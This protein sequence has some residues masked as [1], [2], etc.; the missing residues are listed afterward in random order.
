MLKRIFSNIALTAL[1]ALG[2]IGLP[3]VAQNEG[4]TANC[5]GGG[6]AMVDGVCRQVRMHS[7][8]NEM[9]VPK[10]IKIGAGS[11]AYYLDPTTQNSSW[12][13]CTSGIG[14]QDSTCVVPYRYGPPAAL[15]TITAGFTKDSPF[16]GG[17]GTSPRWTTTNAVSLTVNCSGVA[18]YNNAN[19]PLQAWPS[20]ILFKSLVTGPVTCVLT[21][22]NS[23][24]E[25]TTLT[26]TANFI[27]P[28]PPTLQVG[29]MRTSFNVGTG[30]SEIYWA[31]QNAVTVYASC[32]GFNWG[33]GYVAVQGNPS[34]VRMDLSYTGTISCTFTATNDVGQT[35]SA[36]ATAYV[37]RPPPPWVTGSYSPANIEAGQQS[38][39]LYNSGNATVIGL[40]CNGLSYAAVQ[41]PS[42]ILNQ[43][44][45][46]FAQT[47]PDPGTQSC[48]I[49]AHNSLGEVAI[50]YFDLVVSPVGSWSGGG[51]TSGMYTY[52]NGT[53][54]PTGPN[55]SSGRLQGYVGS[56]GQTY[57]DPG[58]QN[59]CSNCNT[60]AGMTVNVTSPGADGTGEGGESGS[61]YTSNGS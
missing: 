59:P 7:E 13:K 53:V 37:T 14:S 30:G 4:T 6:E 28:I 18:T 17:S 50:T 52:P 21:A 42:M 43:S 10:R 16:I 58:G 38:Q 22:M 36:S 32:S 34:G 20:G 49:S 3:A 61:T 60:G 2:A 54:D 8:V 47:W 35:E 48:G 11:T 41:T 26:I 27:T 57:S 5:T 29:F 45:Y 44:W 39:L 40:V 24:T 1:L 25:P 9:F 55:A 19:A 51:G 31:S 56:D 33:P 23:D 46:W 12:D 15:A